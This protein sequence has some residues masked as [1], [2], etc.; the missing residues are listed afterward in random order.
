MAN[1]TLDREEWRSFF[2]L[3]GKDTKQVRL[4]SFYPKGHPLKAQDRGAKMST[5]NGAEAVEWIQKNQDAGKGVYFVVN[6]GGDTDSE[7]TNC[8]AFFIEWD[9]R[10]IDEQVYLL[11]LIHI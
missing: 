2:K 9:D 1:T 5:S 8:R 7:I 11:S 3:L 10:D 6:D 4:R